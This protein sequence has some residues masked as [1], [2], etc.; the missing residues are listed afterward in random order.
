MIQLL[1]GEIIWGF[2]SVKDILSVLMVPVALVLLAQWIAHRWQDRQRDSETKTKLVAD[3]SELV[4]STVMTLH[5]FRTSDKQQSN[6]NEQEVDQVYKKWRVDTCVIGS[7]LHAYFPDPKK[8]N[9]QIHKKWRF[10]SDSLSEYYENGSEKENKKSI[11]HWE[12]EK[13]KLFDQKSKI[14]AEILTSKITGFRNT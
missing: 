8:G 2:S 11:E 1:N 4:M 3:I 13:E 5:L 14:I 6:S 7:K 12:K 9:E 10:F